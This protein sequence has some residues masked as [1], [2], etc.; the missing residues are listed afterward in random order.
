MHNNIQ[1]FDKHFKIDVP[2]Q[3]LNQPLLMKNMLKYCTF[4]FRLANS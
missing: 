3:I 4:Q 2:I 1:S